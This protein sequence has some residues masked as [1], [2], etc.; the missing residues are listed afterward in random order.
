MLLHLLGSMRTRSAVVAPTPPPSSADY[1]VDAAAANDSGNGLTPATAKK[2][3]SSGMALMAGQ[4]GKVLQIKNGTYSHANDALTSN[5]GSGSAGNY[6]TVRAETAG[7][8]II[9]STLTLPVSTT[10]LK[11]DGLKWAYA[12]DKG[13]EGT[14]LKFLN[15]IFK[16]GA[17]SGNVVNVLVGTNNVAADSTH[18]IL[19]QDCLIYGAGGR[20][21]LLV[22][23]SKQVV[24]RRVVCRPDGGW[25]DGGSSNPQAGITFYNSNNCS[26][27]NCIIMDAAGVTMATWQGA[28]YGIHNSASTGTSDSNS[29]RG[30]IALNNK[31][32]SMPDGAGLRFDMSSGVQQTNMV[33]TD[34]V[35]WDNY[36]GINQSYSGT[37]QLTTD[38]FTLGQTARQAGYGL[39]GSSAGTKTHSNGII[40]GFNTDDIGNSSPTY[41]CTNNNGATYA[42]TGVVTYNPLTNGLSQLNKID[43]GSPLK[44]AGSGGGQIGAQIEFKWGTDDA[45]VGDSGW[46][47]ITANALFDWPNQAL[48]K[49]CLQE[50]GIT[51]GFAGSTGTF[52][53]YIQ[54]YI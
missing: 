40:Y 28:F 12:N 1:Y 47:T 38:R 13:I 31:N 9:T 36:W 51:R 21:G 33:V 19:F 6:N 8:V 44:T 45:L 14:Y 30:C 54:N 32:A 50:D 37:L 26:A 11:F 5:A 18:H 15:C 53:D 23:Q 41:I 48:W 16:N 7:S 29:W 49:T 46:D 43:V 24:V 22:Y 17:A 39:A 2:Y 3:I 4:T 20:Y 10:Y 34:F 35:A 52:T 25:T 42:G 27:Q